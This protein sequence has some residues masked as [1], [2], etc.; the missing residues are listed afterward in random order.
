MIRG[1][2]GHLVPPYLHPAKLWASVVQFLSP[3]WQFWYSLLWNDGCFQ[4]LS[5][6]CFRRQGDKQDS[7]GES[8]KEMSP[9][10][11]QAREILLPHTWQDFAFKLV[12]VLKKASSR[13][14]LLLSIPSEAARIDTALL[15]CWGTAALSHQN[16]SEWT[17]LLD[18][19]L[20]QGSA[21]TSVLS[22]PNEFQSN[23][24]S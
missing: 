19:L 15:R 11:L 20:F 16:T 3:M 13:N 21:K 14:A 24:K 23:R 2:C 10:W 4:S 7:E 9:T 22:N 8:P 17:D 1:E 6:L 18:L 12:L 5:P